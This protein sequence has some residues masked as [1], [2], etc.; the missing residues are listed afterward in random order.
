MLFRPHPDTSDYAKQL[1]DS[2]GTFR[3]PTPGTAQVLRHIGYYDIPGEVMSHLRTRKPQIDPVVWGR[4]QSFVEDAVALTAPQLPY[5]AGLTQSVLA[6]YIEWLVLV[7]HLPLDGRIAFSRQM[8]D[9]YVTDANTHL[10][11]GTRRNYRAVLDRIS[12]LLCPEEHPYSYT[13][14]NRKSTVAPYTEAEMQQFRAWAAGQSQPVKR[15]RGMTMLTLCAGAGLTSGEVPLIT[16]ERVEVSD[17]GIVIDVPSKNPRSV[18]LLSE[19]DAWMHALL[20]DC[21]A[22]ETLW[23]EIKRKNHS[24]LLSTFVENAEGKGLGPRGDRLR[25]TWLVWHLN[26]RTPMKDLFYAAGF[27]KM[28]HLPRLL[29]HVEF[30][31]PEDYTQVLRGE[32]K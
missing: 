19:W 12:K 3:R 16:P 5:P 14:Q 28:E 4:I 27:R 25:N 13:P 7:K 17:A 2:L 15:R 21:S 32:A 9:L 31:L 18:P 6:G 1:L 30:L 29:A 8:I 24:N 22:T 11:P 20:E 26:N 10:K 23:G